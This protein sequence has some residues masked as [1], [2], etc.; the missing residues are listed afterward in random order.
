[1]SLCVRKPI[2]K[3]VSYFLVISVEGTTKQLVLDAFDSI[4][5]CISNI[6]FGYLG[7]FSS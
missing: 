4:L 7:K 5:T 2:S 1:M 3:K 6:S